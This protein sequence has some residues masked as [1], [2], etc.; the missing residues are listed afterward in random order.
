M[1]TRHL[2]S[3][4]SNSP[5]AHCPSQDSKMSLVLQNGS[6]K[7]VVGMKTEFKYPHHPVCCLKKTQNL[8]NTH[9]HSSTPT[10][11]GVSS[12]TNDD[13]CTI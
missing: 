1:N 4:S 6:L 10:G 7:L 3:P 11:V 2:P 12:L 9:N 5:A 8:Q 13:T